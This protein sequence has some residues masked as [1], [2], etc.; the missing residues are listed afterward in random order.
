MAASPNNSASRGAGASFRALAAG[1]EIV[2]I[3]LLCIV[4][5]ALYGIVHDQFTAR[6]CVEYF[7]IGHPPLFHSD[8]PTLLAF[9]WGVVATWWA[10]AILGVPAAVFCQFGPWPKYEVRRLIAPICVLLS[11]MGVAALVTGTASYWAAQNGHL[12]L[13]EPLASRIGPAKEA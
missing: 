10:G 2:K 4:A 8:S 5:A 9:G 11:V 3:V 1:V 7:S 13:H 6:I 12:F